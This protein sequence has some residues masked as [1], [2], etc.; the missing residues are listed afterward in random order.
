[1]EN[2]NEDLEKL[3]IS[4]EIIKLSITIKLII[5]NHIKANNITLKEL[6]DKLSSTE[7]ELWKF[8]KAE[9]FL[10]STAILVSHAIGLDLAITL[11]KI[12][13]V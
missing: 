5:I 2:A 4:M 11:E 13:A 7:A 8:F 1:M 10:F 6:A 3:R 9:D 12:Y